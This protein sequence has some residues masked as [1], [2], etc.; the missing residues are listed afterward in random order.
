M[1]PDNPRTLP[2]LPAT[3]QYSSPALIPSTDNPRTLNALH[4]TTTDSPSTP[5]PSPID[6]TTNHNSAESVIPDRPNQFFTTLDTPQYY[7]V[8]SDEMA[9]RKRKERQNTQ[10]ILGTNEG[11]SHS[12]HTP[13]RKTVRFADQSITLTEQN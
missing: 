3:A 12:P 2:T 5:L 10:S 4:D 9:D 1:S 13:T 7:A 11:H 8:R 6:P